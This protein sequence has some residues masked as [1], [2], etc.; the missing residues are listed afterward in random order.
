VLV[1]ISSRLVD[2]MLVVVPVR[3]HTPNKLVNTFHTLMLQNTLL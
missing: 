1:V 3:I 2:G